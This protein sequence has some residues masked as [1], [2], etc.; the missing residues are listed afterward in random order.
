VSEPLITIGELARRT[1]L[2]VK[3]VRFYSDA[4][5][6]PPAGRS[7]AGYR[8]Y[9]VDAPARLDL[10]RT[11]R[12]LGVDLGTIQRMLA[13]EISVERLEVTRYDRVRLPVPQRPHGGP[14]FAQTAEQAARSPPDQ[15]SSKQL[16]S[17]GG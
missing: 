17:L 6:V 5:V 3:R 1:G 16:P 7:P 10:V 13:M 9:G 11:L 12:D 15:P 2:P 4:G 14:R 8:L